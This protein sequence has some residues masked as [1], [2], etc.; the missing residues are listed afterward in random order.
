[1]TP[2]MISPTPSAFGRQC[3]RRDGAR[4]GLSGFPPTRHPAGAPVRERAPAGTTAPV[5]VDVVI[6]APRGS[7]NKYEWDGERRVMRLD[8]RIPGAVSFPADYGFVPDTC[9]VD[10]DPVD[11]LVL[12]SEPTFPGIWVTAR[13]VG[14][15][16]TDAE[17]YHEPKL[18]CAPVDD[19]SYAEIVDISD[20]PQH[21]I[22]EITQFFDVYKDFDD[23]HGSSVLRFEGHEAARQIVRKARKE[24]EKRAS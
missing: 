21:V 16:W 2:S 22:D 18:I 19:P 6:E 11:A 14:V 4:R 13:P 1:M 8:R 15:C 17:K 3:G 9:G 5:K 10:G 20:V 24:A 12:L 23:G 7:R